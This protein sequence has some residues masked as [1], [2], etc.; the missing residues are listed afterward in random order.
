M[1]EIKNFSGTE[2]VM[3]DGRVLTV[4][5]HAE[6]TNRVFPGWFGDVK[7]GEEYVSEWDILAVD[8][9]GE[10]YRIIYQYD[11]VKGEEPLPEDLDWDDT[12]MITDIQ[13]L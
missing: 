12:A 10:E 4:T 9:D 13:E 2:F 5:R 7:D 8:A 6:L 11:L 1:T 3:A